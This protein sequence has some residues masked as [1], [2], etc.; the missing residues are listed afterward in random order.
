LRTGNRVGPWR[1]EG[2][3][4]RGGMA[5]VYA[6]THTQ[7][8]KRAALK[9]AHRSVLG[10]DFTAATFLR[11]ARVVN[12]V[13][14]VGVPDVFATGSLD[15][16]PYLVMERLSG[17]TLGQQ[18]DAGLARHEAITILLELCDVLA[19]AHAA[20]VVHRDI[21]LDN[22]FIQPAPNPR[23]KLL[24]WGIARILSEEDPLRGMVAGTLTYVPPEQVLGDDISPAADIYSLGVLAYHLLL[25]APPFTASSELD[26]IRKHLHEPPPLPSSRWPEIPAELASVLIAM[27]GK[28]PVQRPSLARVIE[29]LQAHRLEPPQPAQRPSSGHRV[30]GAV[31]AAAIAIAGAIALVTS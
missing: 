15:R 10:P 2:E 11:E 1:V 14:H 16:R 27:L 28:H 24:D 20:G 26:L 25:G 19:A 18:L 7:F 23:I 12:L 31:V 17:A 4:G 3:L 13:G 22:V 5:A 21:K 30:I 9:L 8:G 6:V 29:T